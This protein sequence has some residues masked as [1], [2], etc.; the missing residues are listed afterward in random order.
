MFG[1][2]IMGV[3]QKTAPL[4]LM[5]NK[6]RG[7][8]YLGDF[9]QNFIGH[10]ASEI[11][12]ERIYAPYL[13]RKKDAVVIDLGANIGMFSLYAS[14]YAKQVY[15]YEPAEEHFMVL[16]HML[17]YNGITNVKAIKKAIHMNEGTLPFY[18]NP[19]KTMW[20]L[21]PSVDDKTPPEM[22][23][24]I[25]LDKALEEEKIE[26]VDL[27]KLDIEGTEAEL[28]ASAGFKNAAPKIDV[29]VLET[30]TWNGRHENQVKESLK[31][32]G[33]KGVKK[34]AT[35]ATMLV[36]QKEPFGYL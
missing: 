7:I 29:I 30:H 35:E 16:S 15:A 9:D 6:L 33:F 11:L 17:K 5:D 21:S 36:A 1:I 34:I 25:T 3:V 14:K 19:N 27:L 24:A 4:Y 2:D 18:H 13:E 26:H 23:E 28:L 12:K 10:Q 20:S 8:F 22:V 31:N 32:A